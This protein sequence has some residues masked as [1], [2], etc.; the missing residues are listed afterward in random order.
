MLVML[1][2]WVLTCMSCGKIHMFTVKNY[3]C[4]SY[5]THNVT[6]NSAVVEGLTCISC[7]EIHMFT[8]RIKL[9]LLFIH[10]HNVTANYALVVDPICFFSKKK[11]KLL[12][13]RE[14]KE[15]ETIAIV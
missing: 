14:G 11:N 4:H 13:V 5:I 12:L 2:W 1:L 15:L 9:C 7:N 3:I 6:I 10:I 8:V